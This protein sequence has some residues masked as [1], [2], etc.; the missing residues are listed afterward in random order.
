VTAGDRAH[1]NVDVGGVTRTL[2]R[3]LREPFNAVGEPA[4]QAD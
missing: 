2:P 1:F 4:D 3:H